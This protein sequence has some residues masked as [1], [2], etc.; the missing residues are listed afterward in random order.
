MFHKIDFETW[1][2]KEHFKYYI[3]LIK[4]NYNLTAEL[5]ISQLMEK[6]KDKKLKF[7]P[8]KQIITLQPNLIS[9]SLWKK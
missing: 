3:N 4:T 1:E 9:V 6:I 2:R 7:F 8:T 5:N